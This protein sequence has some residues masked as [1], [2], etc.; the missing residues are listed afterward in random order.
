LI[1]FNNDEDVKKLLKA[2]YEPVTPSPELK[3]EQLK[4]L[5]EVGDAALGAPYPLWRQ[6]KLWIPIAAGLI[7]AAIGYGVWLSLN[8]VPTFIP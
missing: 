4:N 6:P 8:V 2:A 5:A 1:D 7:S 3:E